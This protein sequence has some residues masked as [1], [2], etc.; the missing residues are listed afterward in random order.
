M[1]HRVPEFRPPAVRGT[2]TWQ[3]RYSQTTINAL[4]HTGKFTPV[5]LRKLK[6]INALERTEISRSCY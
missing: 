2:Y 5:L 4:E 3:S 6:T 1:R